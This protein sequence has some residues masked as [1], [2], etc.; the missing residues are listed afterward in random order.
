MT[1]PSLGPRAFV[2]VVLRCGWVG[3]LQMG[4]FDGKFDAPECAGKQA[5]YVT[6]RM[7]VRCINPGSRR[8]RNH[9]LAISPLCLR[10]ASTQRDVLVGVCVSV[11][12]PFGS[13]HERKSQ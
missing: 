13:V 12:Y 2:M 6:L 5:Y 11:R 8:T 3:A 1:W 9:R 7:T 10:L 4:K